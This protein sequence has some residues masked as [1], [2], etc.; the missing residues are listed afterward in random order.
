MIYLVKAAYLDETDT[1]RK[2]L[3]IGYAKDINSR[4]SG[5]G[6]GTSNN[7]NV[8][9]IDSRKGDLG[10][11]FLFH[12]Y[13][14]DKIIKI[15]GNQEWMEYDEKIIEDFKTIQAKDLLLSEYS[16]N[17]IES[18]FCNVIYDHFCDGFNLSLIVSLFQRR[19]GNDMYEM[20]EEFLKCRV[21]MVSDFEDLNEKL[22]SFFPKATI[23]KN[24]FIEDLEISLRNYIIIEEIPAKKRLEEIQLDD[25]D[26]LEKLNQLRNFYYSTSKSFHDNMKLIC[27]TLLD[28]SWVGYLYISDLYWLPLNFRNCL[29]LV[30]PE[31]IRANGYIEAEV[32]KEIK[33]YT[34]DDSLI[35]ELKEKFIIGN[36][37][38]LKETKEM[39]GDIY[40][41]LGIK[42]TPKAS[43]LEKYFNLREIKINDPIS[44]KRI[45]G[46][47]I[48][49]LK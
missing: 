38:S 44:N 43:D 1:P 4:M 34:E 12:K 18:S 24:K 28:P 6:Y 32:L 41:K 20:M 15:K 39:I 31:R 42:Q 33:L 9:L 25:K 8:I 27:E 14:K 10:L 48:L 40:K 30:G 46:Y 35:I 36:R 3:K 2:C 17:P 7:L 19:P 29:Y 5:S 37:Y 23:D 45:A 11:E 21:F 22:I 47:E 16:S 26:M 13:Y 49:S